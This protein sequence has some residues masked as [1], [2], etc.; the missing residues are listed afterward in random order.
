MLWSYIDWKGNV[1]R[2]KASSSPSLQ[3][4]EVFFE[5]LYKC[6]N[7]DELKE[8]MN[9][10][11]DVH[12]PVLDDPISG[13]EI[14]EAFNGM[15]KAGFDYNLPILNVLVTYFMLLLVRIMNMM[16]YVGYPVSLACSLLSIIPKKGNLLLPKNY[17]GIQ[18]L[19]ALACLFDRIIGNRLKLWLPFH[20]DQ[21]AFQKWKSTLI[22]I[23]T[24]RIIIELAKKKNITLYIGSMDIAKAFDHV[25]RSLLLKKLVQLG[26]GKSMLFALKQMYKLTI[27]VLKFQ[28]EFSDSFV[29]ERGIRQG[30]ASSVL[31][32][33]AF[34][35]GLFR[36]LDS[37]CDIET[38]FLE[39]IHAL[40]HA[41]DTIIVSTDRRKF[42]HKCTETIRFFTANKLKLNLDKSGFLIINP[43][44]DRRCNII[45]ESG[46][47]KYKSSFEYLGV[48]I[49]DS[50]TLK[51]DVCA[52]LNLKRANISIKFS[53]FCKVNRNAPVSVKL[54]IL[55]TC[56]TSAITYACETW[57]TNGDIAELCYR[58][59]LKVAL[60][61][62]NNTNNEIVYVESGRYPISCKI[63]K[64]Q[65]KFWLF[66][67]DYMQ[68]F[69]EA[70][71]CKMVKIGVQNN[72]PFIR[73][74]QNLATKYT[75]PGSCEI[76]MKDEHFEKW[77]RKIVAAAEDGD[78]RLGTYYRVNPTLEK[79]VSPPH[80]MEHERILITRFRTGSHS[81]A[82]EIGRYS[83]TPRM[84]RTCACHQSVQSIW[85]VLTE[86][87]LTMLCGRRDYNDLQGAFSDPTISRTLL[88]ISKVLKIPI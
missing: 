15:K 23:F 59:G 45:L 39:Q 40:L 88:S 44:T 43:K 78:S 58:S 55:D 70:A 76:A 56:V 9:L 64:Q 62:R 54:D 34:M 74:Y 73:H 86:C 14:H 33:N 52:F 75:D 85:H 68:K 11:S 29:M 49:S 35:D 69:P 60:G 6:D 65:L 21:T 19:K 18:M 82:I 32:F 80:L 24:L 72:I 66:V 37:K 63:R 5:D 31:L 71:L 27:C 53:N 48:I 22:H 3:E 79:F 26:V 67:Q 25:P 2:K 36:H 1:G 16:F 84:N 83:N 81:L 7:L 8:I 10:E 38:T 42:I 17:R 13:P 4:F 87:P 12:V 20:V 28:N 77:R 46:V 57:G 61:V 41:D 30:A 47:L 50:G 51:N